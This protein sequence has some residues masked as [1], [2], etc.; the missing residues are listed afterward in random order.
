VRNPSSPPS[1]KLM[2][3]PP[4]LS[5]TAHYPRPRRCH[6]PASLLPVPWPPPPPK[7]S[8]KPPAMNSTPETLTLTRP[9]ALPVLICRAPPPAPP[10]LCHRSCAAAFPSDS[11]LGVGL[12]HVHGEEDEEG[13]GGPGRRAVYTFRIEKRGKADQLRGVWKQSI[14]KVLR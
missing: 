11:T 8:F 5:S 9:W 6:R 12:R 10:R 7:T 13:H 14:F 2:A 3:S 4:H 1:V